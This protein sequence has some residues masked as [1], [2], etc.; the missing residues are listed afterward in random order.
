VGKHIHYLNAFVKREN[1]KKKRFQRFS[2]VKGKSDLG[3][4]G[5]GFGVV[6]LFWREEEKS[7]I[8]ISISIYK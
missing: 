2:S 8:H 1:Q 7:I 3:G 5:G 4:L 6:F